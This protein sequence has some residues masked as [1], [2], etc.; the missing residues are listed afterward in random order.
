MGVLELCQRE[1]L[2]AVVGNDTMQ[3]CKVASW[4]KRKGVKLGATVVS[5]LHTTAFTLHSFKTF[6]K[7]LKMIIASL[8]SSQML[9]VL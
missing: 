8:N 2:P 9:Q 5:S 4:K 7:I 3:D 1:V 6:I